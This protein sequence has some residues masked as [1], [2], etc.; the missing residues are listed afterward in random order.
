MKQKLLDAGLPIVSAV[1]N[2]DGGMDY[3]FERGLSPDEL[4]LFSVLTQPEKP[5]TIEERL[6]AAELMISIILEV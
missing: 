3:I 5:P 2:E 4:K 1:P 6:E